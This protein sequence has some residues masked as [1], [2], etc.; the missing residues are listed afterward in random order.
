MSIVDR[1]GK[2]IK[3]FEDKYRT[4]IENAATAIVAAAVL[5]FAAYKTSP[6]IRSFVNESYETAK[7]TLENV[8]ETVELK[9]NPENFYLKSGS[10]FVKETVKPGDTVSKLVSICTGTNPKLGVNSK[11]AGVRVTFEANPGLP[12]YTM[13][14]G[15]E[16][17]VPFNEKT[18]G[19]LEACLE[20]S[21]GVY[22]LHK[23]P[24]GRTYFVP[25]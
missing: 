1:I 3:E 13:Q 16:L 12:E 21:S 22:T 9:R 17:Y 15:E 24:E 6:T 7:S 18:A 19:D 10:E 14:V 4:T 20:R 25:K 5:S 8:A 23:D 11:Y 2:S